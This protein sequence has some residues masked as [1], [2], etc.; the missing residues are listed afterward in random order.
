MSEHTPAPSDPAADIQA[1]PW[2]LLDEAA[3]YQ[4]EQIATAQSE[5]AHEAA[6]KEHE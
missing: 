2:E 4:R 1:K 6:L 3:E 5:Q